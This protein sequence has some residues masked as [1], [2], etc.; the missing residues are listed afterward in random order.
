MRIQLRAMRLKPITRTIAFL[1]LIVLNTVFQMDFINYISQF[2]QPPIA[3][4]YLE[5]WHGWKGRDHALIC[6][7]LTATDQEFWKTD[8][9]MTNCELLIS[10]EINSYAVSIA[11]GIWGFLLT[12]CILQLGKIVT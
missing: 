3:L 8:R 7:S 9:E 5:G 12:A 11:T 6:S 1:L 10:R 4:L 2:L